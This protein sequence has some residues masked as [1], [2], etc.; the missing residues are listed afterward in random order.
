[1]SRLLLRDLT[2]ISQDEDRRWDEIAAIAQLPDPQSCGSAWQLTA[3]ACSRRSGAPI[4]LRQ[5]RD[6]QIAFALTPA[7]RGCH[8]GPLE[9]HWNF[10][11]PVLGPDGVALLVDCIQQLRKDLKPEQLQIS[12]PG[13]EPGG[14]HARQIDKAF[15]NVRTRVQHPQASASLEGGIEG[16]LSRRSGNFRHN[17]K[18]AQRRANDAGIWFERKSPRTETE[19]AACYDRMLKVEQRSWK[20]PAREGLL[21]LSK[22][23]RMLLIAYAERDAARVVFARRDEEDVG[24]CFGG[25]RFGVYRGQQTS[26]SEQVARLSI[27]TLMHFETAKWLAEDGASLQHFGP[28]EHMM[29][30]KA[31]FCEA[32]SPSVVKTILIR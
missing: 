13:L 29:L 18:R 11:S 14:R 23:Y 9:A 25:A 2:D 20:G 30:Y 6:S 31:S 21:A 1:M 28:V 24:F 4:V 7:L 16:W 32:E 10:G 3:F 22:F 26:Y 17:L 5:T 12:V 15:P 27:G 19:A 8:F